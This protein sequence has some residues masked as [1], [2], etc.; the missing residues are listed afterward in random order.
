[1]SMLAI[2]AV[3]VVVGVG[4]LC[5]ERL[6]AAEPKAGVSNLVVEAETARATITW[7]LDVPHYVDA[8]VWIFFCPEDGVDN[9]CA[10]AHAQDMGL[11]DA[12]PH[13]AVIGPL[14]PGTRYCVRVCA[15]TGGGRTWSDPVWF[16]SREL[17][18][19][20]AARRQRGT[21]MTVK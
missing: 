11:M 16:A 20:Q 17:Q 21:V 1:M 15:V 6:L 2:V 10:W 4:L 13:Q 18:P 19:V 9:P 7:V 14:L 12:G 5:G 3:A 8:G